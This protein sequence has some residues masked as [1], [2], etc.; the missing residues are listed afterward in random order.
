[1]RANWLAF[2]PTRSRTWSFGTGRVSRAAT[3]KLVGD[4]RQSNPELQVAG[5]PNQLTVS[6]LP[7]LS[8]EM[9][10]PSP[11]QGSNGPLTERDTLVTVQRNDGLVVFMIFI[12][13][14]QQFQQF[15]PAFQQMLSSFRLTQ[16]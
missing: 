2:S 15:S 11:V 9:T 8:V 6:G 13:P 16:Q 1:M 7:A 3:A 14:E 12:A 4:L 10:G 5:N